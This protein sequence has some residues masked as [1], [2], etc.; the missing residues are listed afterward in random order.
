M[1]VAGLAMIMYPRSMVVLA[2]KCLRFS[3]LALFHLRLLPR[4]RVL[5]IIECVAFCCVVQVISLS[6]FSAA[7]AADEKTRKNGGF[8]ARTPNNQFKRRCDRGQMGEGTGLVAQL[9]KI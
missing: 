3:G 5:R 6:F 2:F 4:G 9:I 1:R 8:P 7:V